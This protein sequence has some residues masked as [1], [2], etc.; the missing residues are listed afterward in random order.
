M[1]TIIIFVRSIPNITREQ[2]GDFWFD[3]RYTQKL[4]PPSSPLGQYWI[5]NMDPDD[6]STFALTKI[7]IS[8]DPDKA[9][10][11]KIIADILKSPVVR[12]VREYSE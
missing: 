12:T 2:F 7:N 5:G 9:I 10:C 11:N 1:N 6:N 3:V 8:D 4:I